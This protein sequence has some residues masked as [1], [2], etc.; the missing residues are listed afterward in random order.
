MTAI[1]LMTYPFVSSQQI[2]SI[3]ELCVDECLACEENGF[4]RVITDNGRN[5]LEP[6]LSEPF[7]LLTG[8]AIFTISVNF[9]RRRWARTEKFA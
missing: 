5:P 3:S 8:A 7:G 2:P 6:E 1:I 4:G 9:D